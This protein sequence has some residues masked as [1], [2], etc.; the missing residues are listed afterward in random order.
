MLSKTLIGTLV[1]LGAAAFAAPAQAVNYVV[2]NKND[3]GAGSL[4][5]AINQANATAGVVDEIHFNI[6]GGGPNLHVIHLASDLPTVIDDQLD[7]RGY[8]QP[9][10]V[11]A[12]AGAPAVMKIVLD[13]SQVA[14]G[15]VVEADDTLIRG[16]VVH[17]AGSVA[18]DGVGVRVVG[19][20]NR[21]EGNYVGL[22]GF[23]NDTFTHGNLGDGVQIEGDDN[24]VGGN[25]PEDRNVISAN[26]KIAGTDADGVSIL[27]DDNKVKGNAIGTDPLST[28]GQIGNDGAGVRVEGNG[29][30]VGG[31]A[32]AANVISGN[33]TGVV[34]AS[35]EDN[36]IEG[37]LIGTDGTG[38][39]DLGN[40]LGV[41]IESP[42]NVVGGDE[43]F[44]GNVIS[45]STGD[46]VALLS[47]GNVVEANKI[48]TDIWGV[49]ALPNANGIRVAGSGNVIGGSSGFTGNLVS[50]NLFD[51]IKIDQPAG[52]DPFG[53][54]VLDNSI[55]TALN[56]TDPLP[57]GDDGVSILNGSSSTIGASDPE[58]GNV[59]AFNG[60][61]GVNV[62]AGA[63]HSIIGNSIFENDD[64]GIDLADD[65]VTLNDANDVDSGANSLQNHP[66]IT[67]AGT[68]T[69][70]WA[71][72]GRPFTHYR[73]E[74]YGNGASCDVS[75]S[76]EGET[77]LGS[78][79]VWT[80]ALGDV[81][82]STALTTAAAVGDLITAT[83]TVD[84]TLQPAPGRPPSPGPQPIPLPIPFVLG[85]AATSEFSPCVPVT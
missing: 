67:S 30:L 12:V 59:I 77:F 36:A 18:G 58:Y 76:G 53:T 65:G 61:D 44:D 63:G 25:T 82:D 33:A 5:D 31:S 56:G 85:P 14:N 74:L 75:E 51:G 1:V 47:D 4:R 80:D 41:S 69:V 62:V 78:A 22:D 57:N 43:L 37:N 13:A 49:D 19:S 73:I 38:D 7:I 20:G 45:G 50:G 27:G 11:K 32:F 72:D 55:G 10:A 83:A 26:G 42:N 48:G 84:V 64:L 23:H 6:P 35:G 21:L 3:A 52:F 9:G 28:T 71:L 2:Q 81:E 60:G 8:S 16:L 39:L 40:S 54:S 24:M 79:Y 15:L 70:D 34:V 29:N 68:T 17:T 66:E 46:G